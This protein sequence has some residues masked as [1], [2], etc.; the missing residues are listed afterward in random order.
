MI[1]YWEAL[2]D[3]KYLRWFHLNAK[4]SLCKIVGVKREELTLAGGAKKKTG[5]VTLEQVSGGIVE[6]KPLV[7]NTT[8]GQSIAEIHGTDPRA[9]IGKEIV[10]YVTHTQLKG[11]PRNWIRIRERKGKVEQ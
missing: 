6:M 2:M 3:K 4:D 11:K 9:W 5:V 7:L 1:D 8:N 10:L